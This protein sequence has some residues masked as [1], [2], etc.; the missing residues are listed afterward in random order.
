[1]AKVS[2]IQEDE[3]NVLEF[4]TRVILVEEDE[5]YTWQAGDEPG[6][7]EIDYRRVSF[8]RHDDLL[9]RRSE[10]TAGEIE[11]LLLADAVCGWR[12]VAGDPPCT[13]EN[14]RRLPGEVVRALGERWSA[15][16]PPHGAPSVEG[17]AK[18]FYRRVPRHVIYN[19]RRRHVRRGVL[20]TQGVLASMVRY[21]VLGW[22]NVFTIEGR[23]AEFSRENLLRLPLE[24]YLEI[25]EQTQDQFGETADAEE[26]L[27]AEVKNS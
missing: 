11:E 15:N 2:L 7:T 21:M 3:R 19:L 13:R 12:N 6:D 17:D 5:R 1:M 25:V 8:G 27:E 18:I 4:R 26:L 9:Q 24:A 22:E 10:L 14:V 16:A 20:N 23:A